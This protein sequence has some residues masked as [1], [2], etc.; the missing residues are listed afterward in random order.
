MT[1]TLIVASFSQEGEPMSV[2]MVLI[3]AAVSTAGVFDLPAKPQTPIG[4]E[5]EQHNRERVAQIKRDETQPGGLPGRSESSEDTRPRSRAVRKAKP[6][7]DAKDTKS[8]DKS[9]KSEKKDP[10]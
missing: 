2:Q 9:P 4:S 10:P 8:K 6:A 5:L 1:Q 7:D 3:A